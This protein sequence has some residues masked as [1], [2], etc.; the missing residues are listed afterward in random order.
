[1]AGLKLFKDDCAGCHGTPETA[2]KNE[3]D[4]TLYPNA[5]QFALHP[6]DKPDS[7][8]LDRQGWSALHR[9]VRVGRS[10]CT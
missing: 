2:P 10:V 8:V 6:P 1:M 4:V 9:D 5:P 3:L 7:A